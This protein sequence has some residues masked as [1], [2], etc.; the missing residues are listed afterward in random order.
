MKNDMISSS[1]PCHRPYLKAK[2]TAESTQWPALASVGSGT[3]CN[4][5]LIAEEK[6]LQIILTA[7]QSPCFK[8]MGCYLQ[9]DVT[10]L[11]CAFYE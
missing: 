11:E 8:D 2:D 10:Q 3:Y 6:I 5:T 7:L 9:P 4:L 1:Q